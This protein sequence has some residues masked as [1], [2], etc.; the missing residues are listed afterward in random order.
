MRAEEA[1]NP[2]KSRAKRLLLTASAYILG[3]GK[4]RD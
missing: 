1:A 3:D 2:M 4:G